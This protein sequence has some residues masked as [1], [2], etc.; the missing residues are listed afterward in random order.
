M[1]LPALPVTPD[2]AR[3][4]AGRPLLLL[5]DVDG[6]LAPIAQR[7]NEAAVPEDTRHLLEQLVTAKDTHVAIV[8]GRAAENAREIVNV[9]GVWVIG[10][11]G[12]EVAPPNR[13]PSVREEVAPFAERVRSASQQVSEI[14]KEH[15]GIIIEDKQWTASVHYRLADPSIV[16]ELAT[17]VL[18]IA[19]GQGLVV[20]QGKLTWEL[21]PPMPI[22]KG[23][24]ALEL[25]AELGALSEGASVLAAGDDRTDEDMFTALRAA[26]PPA[27]TV[28]VEHEGVDFE[29]AA[30]FAVEN[31]DRLR[32]LLRSIER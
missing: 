22:D 32:D 17:R 20:R 6:T 23:S 3:R 25:A 26:F 29:T 4:L 1:P 31:T 8:S 14:A 30:E 27:V 12:I 21:R 19:E 15:S 10:N 9:D 7:P 2:L 16:P 5:L 18:E 13:T 28:W 11:H 24:T